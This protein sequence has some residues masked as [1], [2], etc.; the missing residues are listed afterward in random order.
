MDKI[1]QFGSVES[2]ISFCLSKPL[3]LSVDSEAV[4][5]QGEWKVHIIPCSL[6]YSCISFPEMGATMSFL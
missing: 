6:A 2:N 4:S 1:V 3:H 5:L